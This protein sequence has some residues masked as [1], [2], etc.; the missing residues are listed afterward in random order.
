LLHR[1]L[2]SFCCDFELGYVN[3]FRIL[4]EGNA[5][6]TSFR[7]ILLLIHTHT[8]TKNKLLGP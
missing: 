2:K 3:A 6:W 4:L 1:A 7:L 5:Y 8:Q